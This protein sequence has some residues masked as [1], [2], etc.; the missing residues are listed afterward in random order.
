MLRLRRLDVAQIFNLLYRR[1]AIGRAQKL[2]TFFRARGVAECNSAIQ[3]VTNLALRFSGKMRNALLKKARLSRS[4][5]ALDTMS[6]TSNSNL[7]HS[8]LFHV[9]TSA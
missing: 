4:L 3:Q 6:C 8:T 9:C 7:F 5:P 1:F 2:T